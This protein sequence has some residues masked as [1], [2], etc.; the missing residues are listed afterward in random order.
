[1]KENA[2]VLLFAILNLRTLILCAYYQTKKSKY[3]RNALFI[4]GTPNDFVKFDYYKRKSNFYEKVLL[5]RGAKFRK[6]FN[7]NQDE[8]SRQV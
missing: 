6:E 5:N 7:I 4:Y 2:K 3:F 1:M 8:K